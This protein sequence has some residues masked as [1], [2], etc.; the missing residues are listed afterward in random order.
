MDIQTATS[1][2]LL[3]LLLVFS[4]DFERHYT[5]GFHEMAFNPFARFL[6]GMLVVYIS[7]WNVTVGAVALL[8]VFFWIAD[9]HL[10]SFPTKTH[11][12]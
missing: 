4:L 12:D 7:S 9:V 6:G 3:A 2:G 5:F 10:L 8:I 11:R 1:V